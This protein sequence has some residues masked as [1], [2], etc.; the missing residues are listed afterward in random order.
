[1]IVI[2][3]GKSP[4]HNQLTSATFETLEASVKKSLKEQLLKEQK[5][6]CAYCMTRIGLDT[7]K[8][9]HYL[10]QTKYP[11]LQLDY[12]NLLAVCRGGSEQRGLEL[13][14][15]TKKGNQ[16]LQVLNP[17][18]APT[19]ETLYYHEDGT[20]DATNQQVVED[21]TQVLNLNAKSRYFASNR[22]NVWQH[23]IT[24][25]MTKKELWTRKEIEKRLAILKGQQTGVATPHSA[26]AIWRLERRL[27][28]S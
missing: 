28:R 10:P 24:R 25:A 1:M 20:M 8:V 4:L 16:Q 15:D 14:C 23:I 17:L 26:M 27:K 6:V 5:G 9:E 11:A 12:T 7:M 13:T 2:Y 18:Q 3:K 19:L 22:Q 21:I